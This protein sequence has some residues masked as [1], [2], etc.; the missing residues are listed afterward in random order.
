MGTA[1]GQLTGNHPLFFL[2]V[3]APAIAA[4]T[5][6][7]SNGGIAGLRRFLGRL[8]EAKVFTNPFS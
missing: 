6:V 8:S 7:A 3:Y 4:F 1:F 2:A 5:L